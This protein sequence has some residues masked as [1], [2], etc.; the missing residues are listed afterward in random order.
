MGLF[1]VFVTELQN[2]K[3]VTKEH[4]AVAICKLQGKAGTT[5]ENNKLNVEIKINVNN[6]K[7]YA[8]QL[9]KA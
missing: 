6:G 4:K 9:R 1:V 3:I 7:L 8:S 5:K 2:G